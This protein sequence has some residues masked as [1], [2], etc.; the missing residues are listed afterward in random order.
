MTGAPVPPAPPSRRCI[1]AAACPPRAGAS[2]SRGA[3]WRTRP[4]SRTGVVQDKL[5][6]PGL[7]KLKRLIDGG[8][9]GRILSVRGEFA[10]RT[11]VF[12]GDWQDAQRRVLAT[13]APRTAARIV[14]DDG[15][16]GEHARH[17]LFAP[18]ESAR[19]GP[20]TANPHPAPLRPRTASPTTP[21]PTTPP[22]APSNSDGGAIRPD[23]L[24]LGGP[25]QPR[26]AGGV[27][28]RRHRGLRG[29]RAAQLPRPARAPPPPSAVCEPGHPRHR[30][31]PRPV[32]S[33]VPDNG[34][35]RQR[36][37]RPSGSCSS[38]H[39]YADAPYHWACWPRA[40]G[41]QLA[42]PGLQVLGRGPPPRRTG[43]RAVTIRLPD[44]A[45]PAADPRT[46]H[47]NPSPSPPVR[48]PSPPVRSSRPRTSSPT[49]TPTPPPTRPPPSTGTPPSP[50]A[51]TCGPTA[52]ASPRPWTPPSAAW[53]WTGRARP[54]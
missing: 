33:E 22:T 30:G 44:A 12:E 48:P 19:P 24:L 20:L 4:A 39:V 45:R 35:V 27:P 11:A 52:W 29:R 1:R 32:A 13:T 5:F 49:R 43:D 10:A 54:S 46:P 8:F 2:W 47:R 40:R 51:A 15:R 38:K 17:E 26:R 3:A 9:S 50:S 53:A 41:V 6:L 34:D 25:R 31:L 21:P 42:E 28:G 14:V 7:L 18:R 37:Q 23:Q 16:P 36:P